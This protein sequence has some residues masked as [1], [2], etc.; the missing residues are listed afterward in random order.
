MRNTNIPISVGDWCYF[1]YNNKTHLALVIEYNERNVIFR[2]GNNKYR[3]GRRFIQRK[4]T[5]DEI[6][7]LIVIN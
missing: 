2:N 4:L 7:K 1:D 6:N 3:R 5:P